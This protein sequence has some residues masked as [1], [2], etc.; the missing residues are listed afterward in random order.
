M[1][2][3]AFAAQAHALKVIPREQLSERHRLAGLLGT[4]GCCAL[5]FEETKDGLAISEVF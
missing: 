4:L 1:R 5:T 3:V 2:A